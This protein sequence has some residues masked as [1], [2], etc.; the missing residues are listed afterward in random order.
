[1]MIIQQKKLI[2]VNDENSRRN[3]DSD[4]VIYLNADKLSQ[5][6]LVGENRKYKEE[7]KETANNTATW[8]LHLQQKRSEAS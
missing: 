2:L 5:C 3:P 6:R 1:M 7:K 8:K 4:L